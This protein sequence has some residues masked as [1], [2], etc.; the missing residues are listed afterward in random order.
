MIQQ[1]QTTQSFI[2]L[3]V[4]ANTIL[5]T[6]PIQ[7]SELPDS[8]KLAILEGVYQIKNY[9]DQENHLLI[10]LVNNL[11][12]KTE[13]Y[14]FKGHVELLT[15]S[16]YDENNDEP[17]PKKEGPIVF[18]GYNQTFYLSQPIIEKGNFTWAEATKNG[19]RIPQSKE[20][21]D[22]IMTLAHK[23]EEVRDLFG[24]QAITVTSW[25][26]DPLTNKR[27]G[28]ASKSTHILGHGIDFNVAGFTPKQV[29]QKLENVWTG[30]LGY[31]RGFTHLDMR[32]Y[33]ARWSYGS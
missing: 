12:E 25:Y 30:G 11:G 29:Q 22:S 18:P 13:W 16:S 2:E 1:T 33:K 24:G 3:K 4:T 21:V 20:I 19:S 27:V 26:R 6:R 7:A 9:D 32:N 23:M 8:E 28:G 31:G 10:D 17:E 14:I 15:L 5:K